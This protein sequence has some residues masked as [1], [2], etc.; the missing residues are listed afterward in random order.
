MPEEKKDQPQKIDPCY[1]ASPAKLLDQIMRMA[2]TRQKLLGKP[3]YSAEQ[4]YNLRRL[5]N[6][7]F[8]K[9]FMRDKLAGTEKEQELMFNAAEAILEIKNGKPVFGTKI[10]AVI[11][12]NEL[13]LTSDKQLQK[14]L[15]KV[16]DLERQGFT[17]ESVEGGVETYSRP[18]KTKE[19]GEAIWEQL[20]DKAKKIVTDY[21]LD[22]QEADEIFNR[23]VQKEIFDIKSNIE[24]YITHFGF[25]NGFIDQFRKI[26]FK[27][28]TAGIRKTRTE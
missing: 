24:G 11:D 23:N 16:D 5:L 3:A 25:K 15:D 1:N 22:A 20:S 18:R 27:N 4:E 14:Y 6:E 7:R 8:V 9:K 26:L 21:S 28:R 13:N 17:K 2:Q 19:E 12:K 10:K